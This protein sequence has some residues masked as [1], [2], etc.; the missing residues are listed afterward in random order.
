MAVPLARLSAAATGAEQNSFL[1]P[2]ECA[3]EY[4]EKGS[5]DPA[6][7]KREGWMPETT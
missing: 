4:L 2:A 5:R 3:L 7:K 1:L 6:E